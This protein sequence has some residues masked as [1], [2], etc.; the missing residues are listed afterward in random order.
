MTKFGFIDFNSTQ[1]FLQPQFNEALLEIEE[2]S[3]AVERVYIRR[4][5]WRTDFPH[6]DCF[7]KALSNSLSMNFNMELR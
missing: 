5:R 6:N 3:F 4:G 7:L 1:S 2:D